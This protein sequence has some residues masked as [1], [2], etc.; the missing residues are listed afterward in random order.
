MVRQYPDIL[1][2]KQV[3]GGGSTYDADGNLV[4]I[5]P[6]E[7]DISVS[8]R[9]EANSSGQYVT[10]QDGQRIDFAWTVY[11]PKSVLEIPT[12]TNITISR[13]GK[14][15]ATGEIKRFTTNQLNANAIL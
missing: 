15:R 9:V 5:S 7:T 14:V 13:D 10:G 2:Y 8:C 3:S 12:G 1:T 11:F 4:V 6:T